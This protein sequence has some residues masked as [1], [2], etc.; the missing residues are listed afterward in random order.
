ME[1]LDQSRSDQIRNLAI[2][3]ADDR[4]ICELLGMDAAQL[5]DEFG[6]ILIKARALRRFSLRKKQ[7]AVAIGGNAS[8]L[9]LLGKD[10]LGQTQKPA[11]TPSDD[12][13]PEP[14]LGPKVG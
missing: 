11:A 5:Q 4:D 10:E 7:T 9:S 12:D 1:D 14:Q 13:W 3:G 6:E 8:M 2:Q